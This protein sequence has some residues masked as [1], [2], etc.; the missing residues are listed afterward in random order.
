MN[1]C[2]FFDQITGKDETS[3]TDIT[4]VHDLVE[5]EQENFHDSRLNLPKR[6]EDASN[7]FE[8]LK[9]FDKSNKNRTG[10]FES[11]SFVWN[12]IKILTLLE[13]ENSC[14]KNHTSN[15][16]EVESMLIEPDKLL[17]ENKNT[18]KIDTTSIQ[19]VVKGYLS[20]NI[21]FY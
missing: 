18:K 13:A 2:S 12:F 3:D 17:I 20:F 6:N 1:P 4:L 15:T 9:C 8:P 7:N 21:C 14:F 5:E 11:D 19:V 10:K 16:S